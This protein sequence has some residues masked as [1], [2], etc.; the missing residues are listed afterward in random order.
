MEHQGRYPEGA[1][2]DLDGNPLAD[3]LALSEKDS[4]LATAIRRVID[5]AQRHP[6]ESAPQFQS[7]I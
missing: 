6:Q 1:P 4:V 7:Y 5:A 2:I 3:L